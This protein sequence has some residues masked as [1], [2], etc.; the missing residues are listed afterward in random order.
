MRPRDYETN[1]I[2][3]ANGVCGSTIRNND[4]DV[5]GDQRLG[6]NVEA[7]ASHTRS[8][9]QVKASIESLA[10]KIGVGRNVSKRVV[11]PRNKFSVR[12]F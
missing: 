10:H 7:L 4:K 9:V 3:K 8:H 12:P 5:L 2:K 11:S 6:V 1:T